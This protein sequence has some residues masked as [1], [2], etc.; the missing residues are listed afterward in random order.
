MSIHKK[1]VALFLIAVI[2]L[3][4]AIAEAN[5]NH[6]GENG[7]RNARAH[8]P[9]TVSVIIKARPELIWRSIHEARTKDSGLSSC[10]ILSENGLNSIV[11]E[12]LAIPVLG[13]ATC[14][15]SLIDLPPNR[16]DYKLIK[17][18]TFK[19]FDGSWILTTGSDRQSTRLDL[20]CNAD[21]KIGVPQFLLRMIVAKKILKRLDFV[22]TL[23]ESKEVQ[24]V[25]KEES[26]LSPFT[27]FAQ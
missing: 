24:T 18:D 9:V 13:D 7:D 3:S 2:A 10:K 16:V 26:R 6:Y 11:E 25:A 17:S 5:T 21:L 8:P 4:T 23:A 15:L 1:L 14:I 27:E 22:K 12:T 19:I 20:S